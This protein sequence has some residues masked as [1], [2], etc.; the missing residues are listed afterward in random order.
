M[1]RLPAYMLYDFAVSMSLLFLVPLAI[2][3]FRSEGRYL[4]ASAVGIVLL[5]TSRVDPGPSSWPFVEGVRAG[6]Q[7]TVLQIA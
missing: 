4:V 6:P 5:W 2:A 1:R 3:G 7:A